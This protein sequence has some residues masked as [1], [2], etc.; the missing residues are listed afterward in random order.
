MT[1]NAEF[2][3][4]EHWAAGQ[5]PAATGT[6]IQWG[7]GALH[8]SLAFDG[9]YLRSYGGDEGYVTGRFVGAKHEGVVGILERLDLTGAFGAARGE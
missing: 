6:G 3:E 2:T 9:N 5:S 1:G 4:L 8:Y 7:D